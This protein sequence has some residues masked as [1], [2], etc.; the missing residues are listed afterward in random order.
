MTRRNELNK[1]FGLMVDRACSHRPGEHQDIADQLGVGERTLTRWKA[2]TVP[3]STEVIQKICRILEI[4][5]SEMEE[6]LRKGR[7][8]YA[9][10][11]FQWGRKNG[12]LLAK[13]ARRYY[14]NSPGLLDYPIVVPKGWIA[15]RPIPL[16]TFDA[17]NIAFLRGYREA[18]RRPVGP[19]FL[20]GE[21]LIEFIN[22]IAPEIVTTDN[23]CYR[24]LEISG[25]YDGLR[26]AFGPTHYFDY[27]NFCEAQL[28]ELAELLYRRQQKGG[29]QESNFRGLL[30]RRAAPIF[31][32]HKRPAAVGVCVF[33]CEMNTP[34]G[35]VFYVQKRSA[36]VLENPYGYH[37]APSGTFQPDS[38]ENAF[39]KRDFAIH[40]TVL[41]ELAEELLGVEEVQDAIRTYDDFLQHPKLEQIRAAIN[42][43]YLKTYF[44]G[45]GFSPTTTKLN[46]LAA[47]T[48]DSSRL[49]ERLRY[50]EH[51]EGSISA[52]SI[53]ELPIWADR[54]D[55]DPTAVA[56]LR[57][58]SPHLDE[59]LKQ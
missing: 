5:P 22:R 31:D 51:W 26:I 35:H 37:L 41:R 18:R 46:I 48:I 9:Q 55:L 4:S 17:K 32:L 50:V 25:S 13:A 19:A 24:P 33:Y 23:F 7:H 40:R 16:Q 39:A 53:D 57:V 8:R 10:D 6:V 11:V 38:S 45:I 56:C 20:N 28:L 42:S 14:G 29:V 52:V 47:L 59:I 49:S 58:V 3:A 30:L 15:K 36:K 54:E 12:S 27:A 44:L 21:T 1:A 43:G 2:G 34:A